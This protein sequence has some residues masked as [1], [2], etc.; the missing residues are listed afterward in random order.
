MKATIKKLL[1]IIWPIE[2]FVQLFNESKASARHFYSW[3]F[4]REKYRG[5][6]NIRLHI[7]C[8]PNVVEG[9]VNIDIWGGPG[10]FAW[11]CRRGIPVDDNSVQT[12]FAEHMF[13]HLDSSDGVR[14]LSECRRCLQ[15]GGV[16]RI[17]VPDAGR[18]L[19]L[20]SGDWAGLVPVRPLVAENDGYRDFWLPNVYRT[21]MEL[22]N[23]VF[24]QGAEHKYAYDAETL[25]LK[26]R[27][28]GFTNV[29]H[30]TYGVSASI[31]APLDNINRSSESLYVEGIK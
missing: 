24:R 16:V 18:Y 13:E 21:K 17:V 9:W 11:D 5:K 26:F 8:G 4:K 25:M 7:G 3:L 29:I 30:Q 20:Y 2:L 14:F 22:I 23:E 15:P 1:S 27:E 31:E 28:A 12:I 6:K 10:A 19:Q